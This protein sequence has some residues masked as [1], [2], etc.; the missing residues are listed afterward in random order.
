MGRKRRGIDQPAIRHKFQQALI[1]SFAQLLTPKALQVA[2][3][4]QGEH[5]FLFKDW[6]GGR[7]DG[8][9]FLARQVENSLRISNIRH[10]EHFK[11]AI[12]RVAFGKI[13]EISV[14]DSEAFEA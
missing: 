1:K 13:H 4:K 10:I 2:I 8:Y 6:L 5:H 14:A 3:A 12:N 9:I 11:K 7:S